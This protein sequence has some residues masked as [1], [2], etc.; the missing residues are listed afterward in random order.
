MQEIDSNTRSSEKELRRM[1][2]VCVCVCGGE[3]SN[4]IHLDA[5]PVLES[6]Q[7]D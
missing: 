5:F 3:R 7:L 2:A 6:V 4:P 1:E